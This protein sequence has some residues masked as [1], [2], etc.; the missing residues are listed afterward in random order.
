MSPKDDICSVAM[1]GCE[2]LL[3]NPQPRR[4]SCAGF[5]GCEFFGLLL[6][7]RALTMWMDRPVRAARATACRTMVPLPE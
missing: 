6:L 5:E 1:S 4:S 3:G 7:A 2:R